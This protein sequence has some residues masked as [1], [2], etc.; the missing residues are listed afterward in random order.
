M[1]YA[2]NG[3]KS[4][5]RR[6]RATHLV[7]AVSMQ[8]PWFKNIVYFLTYG[9]FPEGLNSKQRWDLKLKASKYVIWEDRLYKRLIDWTFLRCVDKQQ[10]EKLLKVF[11]EEA[12]K[13]I[14]LISQ[15]CSKILRQCYYRVWECLKMHTSGCQDVKNVRCLPGSHNSSITPQTRD[16]WR[17]I[18]TVGTWFYWP[19][20]LYV[21]CRSYLYNYGDRLVLQNGWKPRWPKWTTSEIVC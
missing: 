17:T 4:S 18:P 3:G 6:P 11:H 5:K 15:Q 12:A 20:K 16:N 13:E 2:R 10:Q 21:Q 19:Y 1:L 8:D 9:E 14:S 7:L